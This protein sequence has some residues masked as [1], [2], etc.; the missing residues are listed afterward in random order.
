MIFITDEPPSYEDA[1]K[2]PKPSEIITSTNINETET[3]SI[4]ITTSIV[5]SANNNSNAL[6]TV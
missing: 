3:V 4:P 2:L 6:T 1:L 5:N